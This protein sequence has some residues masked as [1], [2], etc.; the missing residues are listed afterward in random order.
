MVD[1]V[2]QEK[3]IVW[4][5]V[6][7]R[8]DIVQLGMTTKVTAFGWMCRLSFSGRTFSVIGFRN[9]SAG[10]EYPR[11]AIRWPFV[12]KIVFSQIRLFLNG[13]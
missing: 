9:T 3:N 13:F 12:Y 4:K 2:L 10:L 6:Q 1:K 5:H 7:L 11:E 8:D